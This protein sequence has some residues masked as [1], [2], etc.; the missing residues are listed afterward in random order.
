VLIIRTGL[1]WFQKH[2]DQNKSNPSI[3]ASKVCVQKI[4]TYDANK[5]KKDRY[6]GVRGRWRYASTKATVPKIA[7]HATAPPSVDPL[8]A[9]TYVPIYWMVRCAQFLACR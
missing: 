6:R 9:Y 7:Q 4:F 1:Y 2:L 3:L 8:F 5:N